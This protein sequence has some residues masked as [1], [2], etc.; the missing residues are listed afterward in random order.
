[1]A[2]KSRRVANI[3]GA[4]VGP[5]K[6]V[7]H[8]DN[9]KGIAAN[10]VK[11]APKDQKALAQDLLLSI[12]QIIADS[13]AY[14]IEVAAKTS[15]IQLGR[16]A[17]LLDEV[18][19][20]FAED[21]LQELKKQIVDEVSSSAS[22][23]ALKSFLLNQIA[24]M[25]D[26]DAKKADIEELKDWMSSNLSSNTDAKIDQVNDESKQESEH[27]QQ[28]EKE[29][30]E[31]GDYKDSTIA[32][33]FDT[34][35]DRIQ[36]QFDALNK[37]VN[38]I[39]G[40]GSILSKIGIAVSGGM[41][42]LMT[43]MSTMKKS[44][45]SP[46]SKI[47]TFVKSPLKKIGGATMSVFK[48]VGSAV[49]S[50]IKKVGNVLSK[51]NP[52][53]SSE[54]K[55]K[56]KKQ[57]ARE[58]AKTRMLNIM[59]KIVEKIWKAVEP[60]IDKVAFFMSLVTKFVIVP[61]ALIAAK[62]LLIVAT[63]AL[64]AIGLYMVYKWV[65]QKVS[66]FI[67]YVVS[68]RMW[69]DIKAK[70]L[71]AWEWLSDFGKWLWD[72]IV[73]ALKY[74][75]VDMWIDLGKWVWEKLTQFGKW[76]YDNYIDK[77]VI[78]PLTKLIQPIANIWVEKI[79]PKI[80]P[81]IDSLLQL[82]DTVFKIFN[83]WDT[84]KSIWENLKNMASLM[85]DAVVQWWDESPFKAFYEANLKPFVDSAKDLFK[86]LSNL[87]GCI[88]G[89]IMDWWNGDSSLSES[90]TN[91]GAT[92]WSTVTD[93]WEGSAFKEYWGKMTNYLNDMAKPI[94]DWYE[95]S[96]LKQWISKVADFGKAIVDGI[97]SWWQQSTIKKWID[98]ATEKVKSLIDKI[99]NAIWDLGVCY[100][101]PFG[102]LVGKPMSLSSEEKDAFKQ[103]QKINSKLEKI[104]SDSKDVDKDIAKI[105]AR[106]KSGDYAKEG[107]WI[108]TTKADLEQEL[109]SKKAEQQR[110]K[111]QAS[112]LA[113]QQVQQAAQPLNELDKIE[114]QQQVEIQNNSKTIST[115]IEQKEVS[116]QE[117]MD[118]LF[119]QN[120]ALLKE[121][122]DFRSEANKK[123]DEPNEHLIVAPVETQSNSAMMASF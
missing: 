90:I 122:K 120:N 52:F 47:A 72:V 2:S 96:S 91:I 9:S 87:G 24:E 19:E 74:I 30:E 65:K 70:M 101:R 71:A 69:A 97:K 50:P 105:E 17:S 15:D 88:K 25:F 119:A 109:A 3:N 93:W 68:G 115:T 100:I 80:Q 31:V 112:D 79:Q 33:N 82:K 22:S 32:K 21:Q 44:I 113:T 103:Q 12:K 94:K 102:F 39:T 57:Q 123:L 81:F 121:M 76:L 95:Q 5:L 77:Y 1:M 56:D 117:Y 4:T 75:F 49:K 37:A 66:E 8:V 14:S 116:N 59:S 13:D 78:Q 110:L 29:D 11:S 61:I 23:S 85:K 67:D 26:S 54:Q 34:L 38:N 48:K 28:K 41:T 18:L 84:N 106:I 60:F 42:R 7:A 98:A 104:A 62:V 73:D 10:A 92:V 6:S 118:A 107:S 83:G 53:A 63:I 40:K 111:K 99:G 114:A 43:A 45:T 20:S 35:Q 16:I 108:G 46:M 58:N 86:R 55:S 64:L 27:S 89:A 51:L 36:K